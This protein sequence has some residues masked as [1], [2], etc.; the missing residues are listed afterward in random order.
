MPEMPQTDDV[1]FYQWPG[2]MASV[3]GGTRTEIKVDRPW[4]AELKVGPAH[5]PFCTKPQNE[6]KRF[7][8]GGGWRLIN[9]SNTPYQRHHGVHKMLIP[10]TCWMA[11][12]M[13]SL[14]GQE[15]I[16]WAM[17]LIQDELNSCWDKPIFVNVH[18][19]SL[20]GQNVMHLHWHIVQYLFDR[21]LDPST[22]AELQYL[23]KEDPRM[24]KLVLCEN[25]QVLVGVGGFRAGQCFIVPQP[26][27]PQVLLPGLAEPISKLVDRF[28]IRFRSKQGFAPDFKI[29]LAWDGQSFS[30][31]IYTPIL[32]H[33]GGAE[34]L[35]MFQ[36]KDMGGE[37]CPITMPWT[38]EKTLEHLNG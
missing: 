21:D 5:C 18:V 38:H 10:A 24:S 32:N 28:N 20:A 16:S 30:Y 4:Q 26:E 13:R 9:N 1:V 15:R 17:R 12:E 36:P 22:K 34:D 31:G 6:L 2:G 27:R 29:S 23:Y 11:E 14:G 25:E 33:L 7:E 37:N 8:Q 35:V 19:G 3:A